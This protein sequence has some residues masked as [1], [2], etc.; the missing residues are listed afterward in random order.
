MTQYCE[1]GQSRLTLHETFRYFLQRIFYYSSDHTTICQPLNRT[2]L[3][4]LKVA[5]ATEAEKFMFD[6]PLNFLTQ[7]QSTE[8]FL[9]EYSKT[10][11]TEKVD[12]G[13]RSRGFNSFSPTIYFD[14]DFAPSLVT[15]RPEEGE[16]QTKQERNIH[17]ISI[18][19][20]GLSHRHRL[21]QRLIAALF[22]FHIRLLQGEKR[23][24]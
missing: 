6:N 12:Y 14:E 23:A 18:N 7:T 17:A 8:L 24:Q 2:F 20:D 16:I 9:S 15:E 10:A 11:A 1:F 13:F 3:V 5:Y 19:M 21:N 4:R 22:P